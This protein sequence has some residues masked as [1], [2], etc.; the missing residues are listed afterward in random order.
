MLQLRR[1]QQLL[2]GDTGITGHFPA[3]FTSADTANRFGL[4]DGHRQ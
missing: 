1:A 2:L 4:D 3:Y